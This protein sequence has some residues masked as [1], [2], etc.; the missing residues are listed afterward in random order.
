MSTEY[1]ERAASEMGALL[2]GIATGSVELA[3]GTGLDRYHRQRKRLQ[4]LTPLLGPLPRFL[5]ED[6]DGWAFWNRIKQLKTYQ[7]RREFIS[8]HYT[9]PYQ[10]RLENR[11]SVPMEQAL[12][13]R[14]LAIEEEVGRGGFGVV[15]RARHVAL[16]ADRAVKVFDPSFFAGEAGPLRR[17]A[18]EAQLL[19][20]LSH[21]NVVR[22]FDA[23]IAG[24]H[25]FIVTEY[26]PA[27]NLQTLVATG[28]V[29]PEP[30]VS[31]ILESA[32][33]AVHH[34]H[35][36]NVFHRDIKPSNLIWH[37]G[38][39][40][41]LDFGAG[42]AIQETLTTRLTT[43][44]VGTPGFIAPELFVDPTLTT[45]GLDVYSLGITAY[46][47]LTGR[48]PYLSDAAKYL[49][50]AGVSMALSEVILRCTRAPEGRY[51]T[52]A[53]LADAVQSIF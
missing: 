7:E 8:V 50:S 11:A 33:L 15:Y 43:G 47:L 51:Q 10:A 26:I 13:Q 48:L 22:F 37:E 21:P 18:R 35:E 4:S 32:A 25:P 16:E 41:V 1:L 34:A 52:A 20:K 9:Q 2:A 49:L 5:E 3:A 30:T 36:N 6:E 44:V 45:A 38:H 23:G 29:L 40:T 42:V 12:A 31:T 39:L 46:Y 17:F 19:A 28:G 27:P 24:R 53:E 14:D